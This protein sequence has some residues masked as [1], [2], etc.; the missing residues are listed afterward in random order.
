MNAIPGHQLHAR[1]LRGLK[2]SPR[3]PAIRAGDETVTYEETYELALR[4]AG[5]LLAATA[6]APR[7]VGVLARKGP[8]AYAGVLAALFTGSPVVPLH[9]DL[10]VARLRYM[11]EASQADVV[12]ADEAGAR[13]LRETGLDLPLVVTDRASGRAL[14]APRSAGDA[15]IAYLLF[16]SGST[17]RPKGLPL[18]HTGLDHHFRLMDQRYDFGPA[19]AFS[20]VLELNFDCVILE[21]FA[22]WGAGATVVHVPTPAYANLP[23]FFAEYGISVWFS[24]PSAIGLVRRLGGLAPGALPGLRWSFFAGEALKCTDV[25]D[26]KTAAPRSLIENLYGPAELTLTIAGHRWSPERSQR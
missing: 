26:W 4:W 21:L 12:L 7:A 14:D 2:I 25:V 3:R 15:D 10:P 6:G 16:T 9:P 1:F 5:S 22:A 8:G 20:Q 19:D 11:L 17:G 18:T 13:A 24:T 23:S